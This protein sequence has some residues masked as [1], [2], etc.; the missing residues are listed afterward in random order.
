MRTG[1]RRRIVHTTS[2]PMAEEKSMEVIPEKT[3]VSKCEDR[4][5]DEQLKE[6]IEERYNKILYDLA[7][8]DNILINLK[9]ILKKSGAKDD[10]VRA[11]LKAINDKT[12]LWLEY[13]VA[14]ATFRN[15]SSNLFEYL[16]SFNE[17]QNFIPN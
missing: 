2:K 7:T 9:G 4:I 11:I 15:D 13:F 1:R 14:T 12:K 10:E 3:T 17:T 8:Q 5:A 16:D 6:L